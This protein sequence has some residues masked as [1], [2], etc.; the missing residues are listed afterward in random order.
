MPML[1]DIMDSDTTLYTSSA[2]VAALVTLSF[3]IVSLFSVYHRNEE[4]RQQKEE[5]ANQKK[6][7]EQNACDEEMFATKKESEAIESALKS[8][9][10]LSAVSTNYIAQEESRDMELNT[11]RNRYS[12]TAATA[13]NQE[14]LGSISVE[15]LHTFDCH[16]ES[17]RLISLMGRIFDVTDDDMYAKDG[18]LAVHS[19]HDITLCMATGKYSE[20]WL[21]RFVQMKPKF[22]KSAEQA[23][24]EFTDSFRSVGQLDKWATDRRKWARLTAEELQ[25]LNA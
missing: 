22:K 21:D 16:N 4:Y 12:N 3:Y 19:G 7:A 17:R 13:K 25:S 20:K 10:K 5:K 1:S 2:L 18:Q 14:S 9:V 6:S 15:Q 24:K 23:L 8:G 11:L